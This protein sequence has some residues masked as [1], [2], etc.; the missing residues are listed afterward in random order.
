MSEAPF[1]I[2]PSRDPDDGR[3]PADL[4]IPDAGDMEG[5]TRDERVRASAR[6]AATASET[7]RWLYSEL[8]NLKERHGSLGPFSIWLRDQ[9][10]TNSDKPLC[11]LMLA[12]AMTE[13][14]EYI[15]KYGDEK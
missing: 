3:D 4:W 5:P 1:D 9:F 10:N 8:Q 12:A 14:G 2:T 7:Q 15:S 6:M 13:I 11:L